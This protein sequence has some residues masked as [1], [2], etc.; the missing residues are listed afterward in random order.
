MVLAGNR[1]VEQDQQPA[2]QFEASGCRLRAEDPVA[3]DLDAV[4][5][6]QVIVVS[7]ER[8]VGLLEG[9]KRAG[10]RL[11]LLKLKRRIERSEADTFLEDE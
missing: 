9:R 11:E 4:V 6:L 3:V 5:S 7:E 10:R 2:P 8:V 1:G